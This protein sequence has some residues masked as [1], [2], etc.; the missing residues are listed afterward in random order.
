MVDAVLDIDII[1]RYE[2][3]EL[4]QEETIKLFQRL[5]DTG[6]AWRLQGHYG[7][8]AQGFIRQGICFPKGEGPARE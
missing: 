1:I 8:A 3:G 2:N 7:R 5:I 4:D 6:M